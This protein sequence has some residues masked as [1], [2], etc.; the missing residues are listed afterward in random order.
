MKC[1]DCKPVKRG[2][3]SCVGLP[4]N[5]DPPQ[6]IWRLCLFKGDQRIITINM[7]SAEYDDLHETLTES[8]KQL[9]RTLL[10]LLIG[11]E[12]DEQE[13]SDNRFDEV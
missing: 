6:D 12:G 7:T 1:Q 10:V 13:D 3:A 4:T 11:E 2:V 9:A 5:P 8:Y